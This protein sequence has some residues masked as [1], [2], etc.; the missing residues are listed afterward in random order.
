MLKPKKI[1]GADLDYELLDRQLDRVKTYVFSIDKYAAF[2]GSL[3]CK[4]NFSWTADIKT[5]CTNGII[6]WWNPYWFQKLPKLTRRTVLM[7]ELWHVGEMDMLRRGDRDPTIWNYACD[8]RIN[9]RLEAQGYSFEGTKPWKDPMNFGFPIG[10]VRFGTSASAEEIYDKLIEIKA[11]QEA[12][13][14]AFAA[15]P[16][17]QESGPDDSDVGDLVD[18]EEND[19]NGD[20]TIIG[21]VVSAEQA[22]KMA[23]EL[24]PGEVETLLK[25]FLQPKVP[26]EAYLYQ[27]YD[28][29]IEKDY[30]WNRPSRRYRDIYLPSLQ[31]EEGLININ[32]YIDVSGSISDGEVIRC[33]SEIKYIKEVFAP[34]KLTLIQFDTR[35]TK[36]TVFKQDDPFD[37]LVIVGRGGTSL[38]PVREHILETKPDAAI[39]FSDLQCE[40]MEKGPE[41]PILW[42]TLNNPKIKP[43]FGD[44]IH[45]RE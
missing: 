3:M 35:I 14:E 11:Q 41:C 38:V 24:I 22:A 1:I 44:Q 31:D 21:N 19:I 23:G 40:P 7:H 43:A 29:K 18:P 5:A 42:I 10:V 27:W 6:L 16:W 20:M 36:I 34:E 32:Y 2:I 13:H 8:I 33:N 37:E 4:L 25:R 12:F 39:I 15:D 45:I 17:G 26:W 9:N 30:R 28:A